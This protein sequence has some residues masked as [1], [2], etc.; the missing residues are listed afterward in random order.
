M[1]LQKMRLPRRRPRQY[2]TQGQL[3]DATKSLSASIEKLSASLAASNASGAALAA[4]VARLET[5][6]VDIEERLSVLEAI[7]I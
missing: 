1:K 2:I 6:A 4:R 7:M 5:Q 3:A